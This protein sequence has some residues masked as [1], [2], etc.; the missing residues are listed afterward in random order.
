MVVSRDGRWG[1]GWVKRVKRLKLPLIK[2]TDPEDA[3][4]SMTTMA[5]IC[6]AYLKV[7]KRVEL[8]S[9]HHKKKNLTMYADGH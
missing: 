5:T 4:C 2:Y 8:R 7:A 3:I 6:T 1:V 9:S